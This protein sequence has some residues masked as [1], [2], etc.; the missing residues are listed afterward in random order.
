VHR[1]GRPEGDRTRF[2]RLL[3]SASALRVRAIAKA[4]APADGAV[5]VVARPGG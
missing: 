2:R 1:A 4:S 5:A 3:R